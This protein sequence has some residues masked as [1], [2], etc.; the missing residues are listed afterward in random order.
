MSSALARPNSEQTTV[1][2]S[3]VAPKARFRINST[4]SQYFKL[5][6][7]ILAGRQEP[8]AS[9]G[10]LED[11]LR[12]KLGVPHAIVVNQGRVGL[13]LSLKALLNPER[14]K[15]I[16]SPYTIYDVVNMVIAA[17]GEP[18]FADI[19]A[20]NCNISP[21]EVERL[22]DD[23]T[24][25]VIITHMHG[26]AADWAPIR[27]ICDRHGVFLVEDAAQSFG[28]LS[29]GR[30]LGT[31]GDVGVFSF[32]LFK[33]INSFFGGAVVC[34]NPEV[35][36]R[37]RQMQ[38]EFGL[39]PRKRLLMR[40]AQG[41]AFEI[42]SHPLVFRTFAF[43]LLRYA[44]L[45]GNE[46][47]QKVVRSEVSPVLRTELPQSYRCKASGLQARFI[48]GQL[49]AFEQLHAKQVEIATAYYEALKDVP[50]I[51]VPDSHPSDG[52]ACL[53]YPIQVEN[54]ADVLRKLMTAGRDCAP[55]HVNNCADLEIF[56]RWR[57]DCR[58]ARRTAVQ[59]I[60]L[61]TY[62]SY[63]LENAH[64]NIAALR[65]IFAEKLER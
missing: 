57:R 50:G 20:D 59:T 9:N 4:A 51:V 45:S 8:D 19:E 14:P 46:Q 17:G 35:A 23:R 54:R 34:R 39:N 38:Q 52:N 7:A 15:V 31:V 60:V 43:W 6:G 62:A 26:V 27:E 55:Q 56:A 42:G 12:D 47:M 65:A 11:M 13:Y 28:T 24:G 1:P 10:E 48:I 5:A 61:P 16:L 37:I 29:H 40:L 44:V 36:G 22:V 2:H 63:G 3:W 30:H 18:V 41:I 64:R 53:S 33:T 32:G 21:A 58:E 49:K 25:A